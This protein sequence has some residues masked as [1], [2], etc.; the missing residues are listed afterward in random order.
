MTAKE[1]FS[2]TIEIEDN[3][4]V[5]LL[6]SS[7][8]SR[9]HA[10]EKESNTKI[11]VKGNRVNIRGEKANVLLVE[12]VFDGIGELYERRKQIYHEDLL[13]CYHILKDNG[14]RDL[15]EYLNKVLFITYD[16][17]YIT[18]RS[19]GQLRL[20]QAMERSE[21][22]FA[23]GPAGTGKTFLSMAWALNCLQRRKVRRIV[24]TRPA[25]EA[26]EKLGFLPGTIEEKVDPYL[27]PLYDALY[28]MAG[29]EKAKEY[30]NAGII[31]VVPLAFMRGRTLNNSFI[32]L[33]EA[34]N[35]SQ[36]QM[37]MFLT[38]MGINSRVVITG[39]ITQIDL[40]SKDKS[41]LVQALSIVKDIEG[42]EIVEL[43]AIDVLRHRLVKKIIDAYANLGYEDKEERSFT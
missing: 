12:K 3:A 32:I 28:D 23:I 39:D 35:S 27:R 24:I 9:L 40:E 18:P 36:K 2:R 34:Q 43:T 17:R 8:S 42:I 37:K 33:D 20:V 4:I 26:G 1:D 30:L 13:M 14:K 31:E 10:L 22:V 11:S 25:I 41:G 21:L 38:R 16:H 29:R 19:P 7:G 5:R 6:T 15:K